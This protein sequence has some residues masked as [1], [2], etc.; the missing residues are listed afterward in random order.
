MRSKFADLS[1]DQSNHNIHRQHQ[2]G[3][4]EYRRQGE[5]CSASGS[6]KASGKRAEEDSGFK[7]NITGQ[8][9]GL[10]AELDPDARGQGLANPFGNH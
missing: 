7:R 5:K 4:A 8:R 2:P 6:G 1:G 10:A 3:A 9:A